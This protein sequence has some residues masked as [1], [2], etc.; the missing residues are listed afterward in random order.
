MV[1]PSV[2][3]TSMAMMVFSLSA[4][5]L[6]EDFQGYG[7]LS[8]DGGRC[9]STVC[10]TGGTSVGGS[11]SSGF[12]EGGSNVGVGGT[13]GSGAGRCA[14]I[15]CGN[16]TLPCKPVEI[17]PSVNWLYG[18]DPSAVLVSIKSG[19]NANLT[20]V[21]KPGCTVSVPTIAS[22][23][24]IAY[25]VASDGEFI[26]W[27]TW[28]SAAACGS[29]ALHYCHIGDCKPAIIPVMTT[30]PDQGTLAAITLGPEYL[31][32]VF[33]NGL[34]GRAGKTAPTP[35][36]LWVDPL[37]KPPMTS[38]ILT[39]IEYFN[40]QLDVTRSGELTQ[41]TSPCQSGFKGGK[42]SILSLGSLPGDTWS[43]SNTMLDVASTVAGSE[44]FI[45]FYSGD[46]NGI[47]FRVARPAGNVEILA[48]TGE[49]TQSPNIFSHLIK[50]VNG[51]VYFE[52][53][54]ANN[55]IGIARLPADSPDFAFDSTVEVLVRSSS[56]YQ[57]AV[58]EDAVYWIECADPPNC[59]TTRL[60]AAAIKP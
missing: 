59:L 36:M 7:P 42:A 34:V 43:Q 13:G 6:V 56:L 44:K 52:V 20:R 53:G 30:W 5:L 4:C 49:I 21:A 14:A 33:A 46:P 58:D 29:L 38:P 47:L 26:S 15:A 32:F 10:P 54:L 28:D 16:A 57:A 39:D 9:D 3:A 27:I 60:M 45:Y 8:A 1:F 18:A 22:T 37:F 19:S 55:Q 40:G 48:P 23:G 31:Y 2:R 17:A 12:G 11:S 24:E 50:V 35:E 41:K 25:G 51:Y